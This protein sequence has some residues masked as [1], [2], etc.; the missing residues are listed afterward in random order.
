MTITAHWQTQI[1]KWETS[2]LTPVI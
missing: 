2:G 1:E